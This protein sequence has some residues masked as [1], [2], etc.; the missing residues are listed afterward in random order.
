M[1][2]AFKE[3]KNTKVVEYVL[4]YDKTWDGDMDHVRQ[5]LSCC[6]DKGISLNKDK[7]RFGE[8][9]VLVEG[10]P[11]SEKGYRISDAITEAISKFTMQVFC[12][13]PEAHIGFVA[14]AGS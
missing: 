3:M 10:Y 13:E 14:Q 5:V 6:R 12:T 2:E 1:D 7:F 8:T 4:I 9:E 11:S